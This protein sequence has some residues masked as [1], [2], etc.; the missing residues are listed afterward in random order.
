MKAYN[1]VHLGAVRSCATLLSPSDA[2]RHAGKGPQR[3]NP[4]E[5]ID[6]PVTTELLIDELGY[7]PLKRTRL[8]CSSNW[9]LAAT[10]K[11]RS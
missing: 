7:L 2:R 3:R 8:T 11:D 9:P 1:A 6:D 4:E 5:A 10:R